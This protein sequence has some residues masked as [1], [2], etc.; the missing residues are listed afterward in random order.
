MPPL[1]QKQNK[2]ITRSFAETD[3]AYRKPEIHPQPSGREA[4]RIAHDRQPR[5]QQQ[6]AAPFF[7][8]RHGALLLR[9]RQRCQRVTPRQQ[10]PEQPG[11]HAAEGVAERCHGQQGAVTV[12]VAMAQGGQYYLR[13]ARK[14]RGGNKGAE[15]K[16]PKAQV[17]HGRL[18][19]GCSCLHHAM[20]YNG[21]TQEPR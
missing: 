3:K 1:H 4:Q 21:S 14:Q 5:Q 17:I 2:R 7:Q 16:T 6:R 19:C 13:A 11:A 20:L 8:L 15:K 12:L 10:P 9:L 18:P